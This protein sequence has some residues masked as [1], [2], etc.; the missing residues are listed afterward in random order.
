MKKA[1]EAT[2]GTYLTLHALVAITFPSGSP[3][4]YMNEPFIL[5]TKRIQDNFIFGIFIKNIFI[6][7]LVPLNVCTLRYLHLK[8]FE[9]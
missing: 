8:T 2:N 6:R 7:I 3:K 1:I 4:G 9:V 5:K